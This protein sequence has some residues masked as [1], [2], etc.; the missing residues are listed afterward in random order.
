MAF[1]ATTHLS[2]AV[3][4]LVLLAGVLHATW[5]AIA[6]TIPD[7]F[8]SSGLIGLGCAVVALVMLPIA[9]L[10]ASGALI[11]VGC[12]TALHVAYTFALMQSTGSATSGTPIRSPAALRRC[13]WPPAR[14]SSPIRD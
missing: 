1:I 8:V 13:W 9:G 5:N 7:Q 6:K 4:L 3:T 2:L 10:P 11:Y 14:G 12:S